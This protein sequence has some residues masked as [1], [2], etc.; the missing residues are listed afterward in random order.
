MDYIAN[1]LTPGPYLPGDSLTLADIQ[2][3]YL[4]LI[5]QAH[6]FA[7]NRPAIR[8]YFV[9]LE[10]RPTLVKAMQIGGPVVHTANTV[11]GLLR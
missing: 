1:A 9:R 3:S 4:L 8:G 11:G 2:L 7:G 6:G 10:A 5:A